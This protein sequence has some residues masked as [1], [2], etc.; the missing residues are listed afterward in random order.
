MALEQCARPLEPHWHLCLLTGAL[1]KREARVDHN[2]SLGGSG[3]GRGKKRTF[4]LAKRSR[5]GYPS[6]RNYLATRSKPWPW[7]GH[8]LYPVL[9]MPGTWLPPAGETRCAILAHRDLPA[10]PCEARK[11]RPNVTL[12]PTTRRAPGSAGISEPTCSY[13]CLN[14][15]NQIVSK[16]NRCVK[17]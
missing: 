3:T 12:K 4:W 7:P 14:C 13:F 1:R 17:I 11:S 16:K 15:L 5:L 2:R 10:M 8:R 6:V 9:A